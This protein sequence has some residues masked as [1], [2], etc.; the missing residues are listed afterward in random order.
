MEHSLTYNGLIN[1]MLKLKVRHLKTDF[2]LS[3]IYF[4][5]MQNC[6]ITNEELNRSANAF[7]ELL[8]LKFFIKK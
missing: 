7:N 6:E 4:E 2:Q 8:G 1:G 3:K 5:K